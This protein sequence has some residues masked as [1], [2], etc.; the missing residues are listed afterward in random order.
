HNQLFTE[1]ALV[2]VLSHPRLSVIDLF[3]G[4]DDVLSLIAYDQY[5]I[6]ITDDCEI[7]WY[8]DH[9][10]IDANSVVPVSGVIRVLVVYDGIELEGEYDAGIDPDFVGVNDPITLKLIIVGSIL[11]LLIAGILL[12]ARRRGSRSGLSEE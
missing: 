7:S 8:G 10:M 12:I 11:V 1:T 6:D 3:M 2:R 4:D 9:V 5:G